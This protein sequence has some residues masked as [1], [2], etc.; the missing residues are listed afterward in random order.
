LK[1]FIN[2][3]D[4]AMDH[5]IRVN[6]NDPEY[7]RLLRV[8]Q[9]PPETLY[10]RGDVSLLSAAAVAIV[11]ARKA[12]EYGRW[13][14]FNMAKNLTEYGL[15]IISGMAFGIDSE[16]HRG[17]LAEGG[18]TVAVLGCG[19]DI[20]YPKSN[21]KLMDEILQKGLV[22]SEMAPGTQPRAFM[23]P[24]RN[25]IISGLALATAVVEAGIKSGALITAERAAEQGR[26]VYAVPG[27]I[28]RASSLGCNKLIQDGAAP[29]ACLDDIAVDLKLTRTEVMEKRRLRLA[30]DEKRVY[31][32]LRCEG[33]MTLDSLC[34][35]LDMPAPALRRVVTDLE[36][37]GL[38]E[39]AMGM[40]FAV[41]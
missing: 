21:F 38:T 2:E 4:F 22:V 1:Y 8:I 29:V 31:E 41:N 17:A 16:A 40:I 3:R 6:K 18:K 23:F 10:C 28:N 39:S 5:I 12:T 36:I 7:P 13:A 34:E 33:E 19:V 11:G 37:K 35:Q 9:N 32:T 26:G 25:R 14:A 27:N 15:A 20:C 24:L 30:A